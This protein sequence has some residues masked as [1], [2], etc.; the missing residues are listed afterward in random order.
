MAVVRRSFAAS[1]PPALTMVWA[2]RLCGENVGV[3][4]AFAAVGSQQ[5]R[6]PDVSVGA[7][8]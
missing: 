1:A 6:V 2:V 5:S 4:V 3:V 8:G 7:T